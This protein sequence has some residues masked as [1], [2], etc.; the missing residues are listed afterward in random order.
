VDLGL[1]GKRALVA[2][3][4]DGLGF[5]IARALAAEGCRVGICSRDRGRIDSAAA[6]ISAETGAEVVPS[7]CDVADPGS[8]TAWVDEAARRWGG[9]DVLVPNAGG[10]PP[11]W[12][13]ETEP[14]DWDAAYRLTLRSAM[15]TARAARPHLGRG[16]AVVFMTSVPV[17]QPLGILALSTIFRAGV[18]V[19]AKL[20][21]DEWAAD[22]IRV[23]HL[24]PG[25][26]ATTRLIELDED[27]A[28]RRGATSG[29]V[30]AGLE[31]SIPL[32]R[33]GDPGELAA[34]VVFLVSE[35]A[36]YVTGATLQVDG[37]M[38]RAL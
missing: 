6:S 3:A 33:Y 28:L 23:N 22:G 34:A 8:A 10:P 30:R 37:G 21:A 27:E 38:M 24:I 13:G 31:R 11:G 2:A 29:E 32:G 1:S 19:L 4:S 14:A 12:F 17:R 36:S 25:R 16:S 15:E 18:S 7:V 9:L 5:A 20:L 35:A 26:I